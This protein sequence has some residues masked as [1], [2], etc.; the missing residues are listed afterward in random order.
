MEGAP[1]RGESKGGNQGGGGAARD[2]LSDY[3]IGEFPGSIFKL[4]I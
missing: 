2:V 3:Q 1:R 4:Q